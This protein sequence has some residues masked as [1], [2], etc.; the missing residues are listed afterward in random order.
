MI[1]KLIALKFLLKS[2]LSLPN[3]IKIVINIK[4]VAM[5]ESKIVFFTS[6]L[7]KTV[8][9]INVI[10]RKVGNEYKT[11]YKY[12]KITYPPKLES[13]CCDIIIVAIISIIIA[14]EIVVNHN[15][16]V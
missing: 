8:L 4:I 3:T 16:K 5:L 12:V 1:E 11:L 13:I 9:C 6:R 7:F 2:Y 10:I 15:F 14:I